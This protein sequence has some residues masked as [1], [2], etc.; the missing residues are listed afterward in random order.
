[1]ATSVKPHAAPTQ[2]QIVEAHVFRFKTSDEADLL[3]QM[4]PTA[5]G[6]GTRPK[7]PCER[8]RGPTVAGGER[9]CPRGRASP[10]NLC[11]ACVCTRNVA[12]YLSM[13]A[14]LI[15]Q[16]PYPGACELSELQAYQ[17]TSN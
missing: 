17:Q 4:H 11:I 8:S 5:L 6:T 2:P 7:Q 13:A 1:M 9:P 15:A 14:M 3:A 16:G 10:S 12:R